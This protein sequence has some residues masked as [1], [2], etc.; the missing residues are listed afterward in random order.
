MSEK[1][2]C[3]KAVR[4]SQKMD[5]SMKSYGQKNKMDDSEVIRAAIKYFLKNKYQK[6]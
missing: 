5:E 2:T 3:F 1:F 4:I 6:D